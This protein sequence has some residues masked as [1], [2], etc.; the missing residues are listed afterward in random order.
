[1]I[2]GCTNFNLDHASAMQTCNYTYVLMYIHW[3][4]HCTSIT[5]N[6]ASTLLCW[7]LLHA[8]GVKVSCLEK[9]MNCH[10]DVSSQQGNLLSMHYWL[11]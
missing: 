5:C 10:S 3:H 7:V 11:F 8:K 2:T 6:R 1:M 9:N 4:W